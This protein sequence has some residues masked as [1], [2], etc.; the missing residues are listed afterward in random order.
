MENL[1]INTKTLRLSQ[2]KVYVQY[3]CVYD[4]VEEKVSLAATNAWNLISMLYVSLY[5]I[6]FFF[7]NFF[8]FYEFFIQVYCAIFHSKT[9]NDKS[10]KI[11]V[12][13]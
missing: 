4:S 13:T 10:W 8:T 6:N 3:M 5:L 2:Q 7:E 12:C 9:W 1:Q 11:F